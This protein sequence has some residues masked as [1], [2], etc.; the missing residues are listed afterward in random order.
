MGA[1]KNRLT[2]T[3][4]KSTQNMLK[5]TDKKIITISCSL[6]NLMGA[7]VYLYSWLKGEKSHKAYGQFNHQIFCDVPTLFTQTWNTEI[8]KLGQK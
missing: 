6:I 2:E 7:W 1:Q 3:V 4:L 8:D 5:A